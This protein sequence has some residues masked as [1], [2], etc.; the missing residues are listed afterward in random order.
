[1]LEEYLFRSFKFLQH[2]C[3]IF[4]PHDSTNLIQ[5]FGLPYIPLSILVNTAELK[6][7]TNKSRSPRIAMELRTHMSEPLLMVRMTIC[8]FID[9]QDDNMRAFVFE[10]KE[11][12]TG[13]TAV[14]LPIP[15]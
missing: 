5:I 7:L 13:I 4:L 12:T 8:V 14:Q 11:N 2:G 6:K 1:M 10:D 15:S 3:T 9:G